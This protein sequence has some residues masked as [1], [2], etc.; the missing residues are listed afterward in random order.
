MYSRFPTMADLISVSV[1]GLHIV[2]HIIH[3]YVIEA[4]LPR[5]SSPG[6]GYTDILFSNAR[7][8]LIGSGGK[9]CLRGSCL[10]LHYCILI[11]TDI[12]TA[13]GSVKS[14]EVGFFQFLTHRALVVVII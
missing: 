11:H 9:L 3:L 1:F 12:L 14:S 2:A 8:L 7:D 13:G 5:R 6:H 4:T 10:R